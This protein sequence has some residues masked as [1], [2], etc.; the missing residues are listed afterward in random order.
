MKRDMDLVRQILMQVEEADGPVPYADL[1]DSEHGMQVVVYHVNLM[2]AH[3]LLDAKTEYVMGKQGRFARGGTVQSLTWDGHDYLEA[4]R[5][6]GV[7]ARTKEAIRAS[8]GSTTMGL[9]KEVAVAVSKQTIMAGL[10]M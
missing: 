3:G 9:I 10:G 7:W 1:V 6:D 5:N 2:A 4:I 8:V